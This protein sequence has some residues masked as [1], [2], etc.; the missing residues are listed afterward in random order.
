MILPSVIRA[1]AIGAIGGA[2]AF[3]LGVPAPWLAGSLVATIVA[4][5]ANQK[6][7]LPEACGHWPSSCWASKPDQPSMPIRCTG[8]RNGR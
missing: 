1:L 6:L 8:R 3:V 4:L 5:Y 2:L 7:D